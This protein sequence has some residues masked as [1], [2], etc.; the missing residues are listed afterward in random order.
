MIPNSEKD[1]Q[2]ATYRQKAIAMKTLKAV[3]SSSASVCLVASAASVFIAESAE[4]AIHYTAADITLSAGNINTNIDVDGGGNDV[5]F[6]YFDR[7]AAA[8]LIIGSVAGLGGGSFGKQGGQ[9]INFAANA[10]IGGGGTAWTNYA[11]EFFKFVGN[12]TGGTFKTTGFITSP[13]NFSD[14]HPGYV[15]IKLGSGNYGWV[16]IDSIAADATSYHID[17]YA[18]ADGGVSIQAGEGSGGGSAV[19]EPSG[20][21]LLACG[22][23]GIHALRRKKNEVA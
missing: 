5:Y 22:A 3:G 18:Y 13:F 17:G 14:V 11:A 23:A 21:A 9:V 2:L 10:T 15:G 1:Q 4:G 19:P 7:G 8:D 16:H 20:L 12:A 6:K